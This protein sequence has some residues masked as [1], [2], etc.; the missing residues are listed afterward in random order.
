MIHFDFQQENSKFLSLT[1]TV[2]KVD[3]NGKN[4]NIINIYKNKRILPKILSI[5]RWNIRVFFSP[6]GITF[7]SYSPQGHEN[8]I[9]GLLSFSN[10]I[11]QNPLLQ[12]TWEKY[13]HPWIE[14]IK[15]SLFGI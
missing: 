9:H 14:L 1:L 6:H 11:C 3:R 8:V 4:K 7:H 15:E 10:L 5:I 13:L 12:S 2:W